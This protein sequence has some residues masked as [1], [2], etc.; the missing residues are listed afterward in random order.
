MGVIGLLLFAGA[1]GPWLES[2][3]QKRAKKT[4]KKA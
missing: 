2:K 3:F 4:A 1:L